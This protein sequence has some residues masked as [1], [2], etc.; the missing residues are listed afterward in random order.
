VDRGS[1]GGQPDAG[2]HRLSKPTQDFLRR[3]QTTALV[4]VQH[5]EAAFCKRRREHPGPVAAL[6]ALFGAHQGQNPT[7]ADRFGYLPKRGAESFFAPHAV[8]ID[9]SGD[10][11]IRVY[12]LAPPAHPPGT[13]IRWRPYLG[14]PGAPF[15]EN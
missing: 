8:E 5:G 1:A 12:V 14:V 6:G 7:L 13:G 3:F 2:T 10:H 4:D 15:C 11:T 9:L